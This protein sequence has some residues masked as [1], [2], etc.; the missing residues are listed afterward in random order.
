MKTCV[1]DE[2]IYMIKGFQKLS[3][4]KGNIEIKKVCGWIIL[5]SSIII[6]LTFGVENST[7]MK[8]IM[9]IIGLIGIYDVINMI[10]GE[11]QFF[12]YLIY[13]FV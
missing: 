12:I 10:K 8:I 2:H 13:F 5:I 9:L 6:L 1:I 4:L 11:E 3:Y 7:L